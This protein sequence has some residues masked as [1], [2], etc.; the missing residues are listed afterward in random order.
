ME[1]PAPITYPRPGPGM[2]FTQATL[3][4]LKEIEELGM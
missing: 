4:G 2:N 3:I 1:G